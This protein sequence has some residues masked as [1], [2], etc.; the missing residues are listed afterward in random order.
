MGCCASVSAVQEPDPCTPVNLEKA[1]LVDQDFHSVVHNRLRKLQDLDFSTKVP[2]ILIE[3]TGEGHGEG[4]I[5]VTGKDEYG[6]Y[7]AMENFFLARWGCEKLD[8]G[9]DT[10]DTKIPFCKA[11]YRWPGFT[12]GDGEDGLN[13]LGKK[14]MEIIDFMCGTLSWTLAVVN[15]GNVGENRDVRETQLI[16]KAPHPMNLVAPHLMVELRS[17]GF[18][19][20]CGDLD[21][22]HGDI[23]DTLDAYFADRFVAQRID[24]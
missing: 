24:G 10:E 1:M 3:L 23:L 13:N 4:E 8:A 18:I 9:D 6:V 21:E 7:E 14:T 12:V 15:G 2:F 19:E 11:Q 17:A 22:E 5:E 16:F 20:I